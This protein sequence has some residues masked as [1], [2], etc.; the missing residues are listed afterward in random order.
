VWLVVS[1]GYSFRSACLAVGVCEASLRSWHARFR[2][3]L[4]RLALAAIFPQKLSQSQYNRAQ[5]ALI[6]T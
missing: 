1:E 2:P 3:Q 4:E 6:V 5:N